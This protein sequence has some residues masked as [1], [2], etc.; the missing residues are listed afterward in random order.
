[1]HSLIVTAEGQK[2]PLAKNKLS[3]NWL[4]SLKRA[5][6]LGGCWAPPFSGVVSSGRGCS[7]NVGFRVNRAG[8]T[9]TRVLVSA[10]P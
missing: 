2:R 4:D 5:E 9:S 10:V 3:I 1:M 7:V 6:T 8:F